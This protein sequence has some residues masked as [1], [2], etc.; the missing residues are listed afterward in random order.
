MLV[1]LCSIIHVIFVSCVVSCVQVARNKSKKGGVQKR[2]YTWGGISWHGKTALNAWTASEATACIWR[3]TKHICVGTVFKD[4]DIVWRVTESR[5]RE[6][7]YEGW[8]VRYCDHFANED[9]D[10]ARDECQVSSYAEVKE[11]HEATAAQLRLEPT[12][13]PPTVG[14]D[15]DK[16]LEIYEQDLYPVMRDQRLTRLVEDN[17]SPHNSKRIRE[18]HDEHGIEIVGY[19]ATEAEKVEIVRLITE[20]TRDYRREQDKRAQITKQTRELERLPAWPPNSPDDLNLIEVV[21][22]WIVKKMS[23]SDQ[24]WPNRPEDLRRA[25]VN[26]WNEVSLD[27]F[28]EL[29][30]GYRNRLECICSVDGDRHPQ[31]A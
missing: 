16:T 31:F 2:V 3:H 1:V 28:R 13:K 30:L 26:A 23:T 6:Q 19:T 11:W 18:K 27:S 25:A 24:G 17:A 20:Q 22:S 7:E 12:L 5:H 15:I 14:Q 8:V 21:W 29:I 10:P 9:A 4:D